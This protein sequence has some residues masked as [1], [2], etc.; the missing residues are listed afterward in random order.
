MMAEAANNVRIL[1]FLTQDAILADNLSLR[2][3]VDAFQDP[4]VVVAYG[5]QLPRPQANPL[6]AH[7]RLYNYPESSEVRSGNDIDRLGIR[8][9]FCSNSF[10]AYRR[11]VL[12]ELGG[13]PRK[14]I[15]IEDSIVAAKALL[16]GWKVAYVAEATAIHSHGYTPA[17][18]FSRYFDIGVAHSQNHALLSRFGTAH[19]E[20]ARFLWSEL[21]Y[22]SKHK[23]TDI[24]TCLV[25][26]ALKLAGYRIGRTAQRLP[27]ALNRK[28]SMHKHF[29]R[30]P[31]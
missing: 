19:N 2:R 9:A 23:P 27:R 21:R 31:S 24:P 5:R 7:A 28:L 14:Q 12:M 29:W 8:A 10:A 18:E 22:L 16:D 15:M 13:F 25:R 17:E 26:T 20:G 6:E 30:T 11:D 4:K 1:V 3:L